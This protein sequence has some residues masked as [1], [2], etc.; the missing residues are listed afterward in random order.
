MDLELRNAVAVVTGGASGIGRA[1]AE[2]FAEEGPAVALWDPA[3]GT[4]A[5]A[6]DL[7]GRTDV[8]TH[9]V[10]LDV[11]DGDAV[12]RAVEATEAAL[13]PL[14]HVVHAAAIGSGR[15]GF[16]FTNLE[17]ADWRRV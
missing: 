16:P 12:L 8:R 13:G 14:R 5:V 4:P 11:T 9:G 17:P 6:A 15:F 1:V 3:E 2:A 7:A 10:T